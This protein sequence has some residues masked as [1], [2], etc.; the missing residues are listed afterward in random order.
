MLLIWLLICVIGYLVQTKMQFYGLAV[1]VGVVMGGIQSLSRST[2]SKLIYKY[3]GEHTSFFSFYDVLE[4]LSVLVG[5]FSFGFIE[6]ITGGMRNSIIA[7][8]IFFI[9]GLLLLRRAKLAPPS[10][11][12]TWHA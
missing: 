10:Q 9:T 4:K 1:I 8:M 5:T 3:E 6:Q 11:T 2:Y 7:L 12:T